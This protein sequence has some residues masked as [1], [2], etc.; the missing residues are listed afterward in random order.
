VALKVEDFQEGFKVSGRG[1]LHFSILMEN[2]RREGFEFQVGKPRVIYRE[3]G[4]VK[5]EPVE[6]LIVQAPA[7]FAGRVIEALG[8]RRGE[9]AK[10]E[11]Q[12][13]RILLE[14]RVPSRGLMGM[15]SR[16]MNLTQGE[17]LVFHSF[18]AY[19]EY[20]GSIPGRGAGV[21]VSSETG[22]ASPYSL[23]NLKDRGP[24]FVEPGTKVYE[25]MIVGE[26]C[27]ENDIAVNV[28]RR[29]RMTNVRAAGCDENV[30][31]KSPR[32]MSLEES[33]EYIEDDEYLEVTPL[34]YRLR[35][36]VLNDKVRRKES[37]TAKD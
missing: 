27:K 35:K 29:K 28:C 32:H 10:Y 24:M 22:V 14:F 12:G 15:A 2:M 1:V 19:E 18:A 25:G 7:E 13:E 23:F 17:A 9:M 21:M 16:L 33:L 26:H 37:R 4:G 11:P 36:K 20:K 34:T 5:K 6:L 8:G 3:E 30:I 31:L